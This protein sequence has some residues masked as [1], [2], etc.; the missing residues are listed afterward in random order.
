MA[1][2]KPVSDATKIAAVEALLSGEHYAAVGKR[3]KIKSH[4][5]LYEWRKAYSQGKLG[6]GAK[7]NGAAPAKPKTPE[8]LFDDR[9]RQAVI[10]LRHAEEE[11]ERLK[12]QGKIKEAD[13]AHLYAGL[14]LRILQGDN[15]R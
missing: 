6:A 3:F 13:S 8:A 15:G 4:S 7:S 14:A 2:G 9:V 12:R 5:R 11:V 10:L 1:R